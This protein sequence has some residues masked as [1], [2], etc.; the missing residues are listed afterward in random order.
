MDSEKWSAVEELLAASL[1]LPNRERAIFTAR[2]T[3]PTIRNEVIS[4]LK[5][6]TS[7]D[8]RLESVIGGATG[9]PELYGAGP[10]PA[11]FE[12]SREVGQGGMGTVY[13]AID[14][15]RNLRV[16]LKSLS[17]LSPAHL[18]SFK[19][20]F[21]SLRG[22]VHPNL[23]TLY[24]LI[25]EDDAYFL[26]MEFIEGVDFL[27]YVWEASGR[28]YNSERVRA[29]LRQIAAGLAAIHAAGK[30][31]RDIKPSNLMVRHDGRVVILDFGLVADI[32]RS[33]FGVRTEALIG[34]T[35]GYIAPE[36]AAGLLDPASDWYSLGVVLFEALTGRLPPEP[37]FSE[38]GH[39]CPED[40][41][42]LC[43]SLLHLDPAKR[44]SANE[45]LRILGAPSPAAPISAANHRSRPPFVNRLEEMSRLE[46]A[47]S[48][49]CSGRPTVV[50]LSGA[51]GSGKSRL[52][53]RFLERASSATHAI[54]LS[55]KCYEQETVP[56]K[57]VD[58]LIDQLSR[59]LSGSS[60][61][62]RESVIPR[63]MAAL[64]SVFPVLASLP[65]SIP[66]G[67]SPAI[68]DRVELRR[69]AL[70]A[71]REMLDAIG[72]QSR[73][74]LWLDDFQWSDRDT[75]E[76]L[77]EILRPPETPPLLLLCSY[78]S[79]ESPTGHSAVNVLL[80]GLQREPIEKIII[81][82]QPLGTEDAAILAQSILA[83]DSSSNI[84]LREHALAIARDSGGVP[85]FVIEL[86]QA[87]ASHAGENIS[88][89]SMIWER[90]AEQDADARRFMYLTAIAG[91]PVTQ[92]AVFSAAGIVSRSPSIL[93][94]LEN[95]GLLCA[96]GPSPVDT[97]EPFHDRIR[98]AIT[99]RIRLEEKQALHLRLAEALELDQS[100]D[101]ELMAV[102]FEAGGQ[103]TRAGGYYRQAA[104]RAADALAF[105]RAADLYEQTLR[106]VELSPSE[107]SDVELKLA[108]AFA[109]AGRSADASHHYLSAAEHLPPAERLRVEGLASYHLCVAGHLN[110]GRNQIQQ[111]LRRIGRRLVS[112]GFQTMAAL[113]WRDFRCRLRGMQ[114]PPRGAGDVDPVLLAQIDLLWFAAA[115]LGTSDLLGGF[116]LLLWS[117][118][119]AQRAREPAR[120]VRAFSFHAALQF[121]RR[122][123]DSKTDRIFRRCHE[124]SK[125]IGEP[126]ESRAALA[127]TTGIRHYFLGIWPE[128]LS[129]CN[130]AERIM[131]EECHGMNWELAFARVLI[132]TLLMYLGE[133]A[134]LQDLS[135]TM[136]EDAVNRGDLATAATMASLPLPYSQIVSGKPSLARETWRYW[137][138]RWPHRVNSNQESTGVLVE[139][140]SHLYEGEIATAFAV[141]QQAWK[142]SIAGS[143]NLRIPVA[144][145]YFL[146]TRARL[147]LQMAEKSPRDERA[148]LIRKTKGIV[149]KLRRSHCVHAPAHVALIEALTLAM[150]R[151]A[152]R[153]VESM[154]RA[155]SI[156]AQCNMKTHASA[157]RAALGR[158]IGGDRGKQLM[159][160]ADQALR[161]E[162]M[163]DPAAVI[164]MHVGEI[165]PFL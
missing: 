42:R 23:V 125:S 32:E 76:L 136:L 155:S 132:L 135:R 134:R 111:S 49:L 120:M 115:A 8:G 80:E 17:R 13:E 74:I 102:H 29:C 112:P 6:A 70:R 122:L 61:F 56:Y 123:N 20:E 24:E 69:R 44:P 11:R 131:V 160:E 139:A 128:A 10:F 114:Q 33:R 162:R 68:T 28:T 156:F 118:D 66:D 79:D 94:A 40:L 104:G 77:T 31:H 45:V 52:A 96:A 154:T 85:F 108:A 153:A 60:C 101:T 100:A 75:A 59:V 47:F 109:N 150:E 158:W 129:H 16:A 138:E 157:T 50:L 121:A 21:R 19:Q 140:W 110:E 116:Y 148:K 149:G 133:G 163:P 22:V 73:L 165:H 105:N 27:E 12:V 106:L 35:K 127:L 84:G 159:V 124:L 78:R 37:G 81:S 83:R 67:R 161:A 92:A 63:D 142:Q 26:S 25:Q 95:A 5:R 87:A 88:V 86:T 143:G 51:A 54:V 97:V 2:I 103:L 46:S 89:Q 71:L 57:G 9:L 152:S 151:R 41:V 164:R 65:F 126:P 48:V 1:A 141:L 38:I 14:T 64:S 98:E 30:L 34:G 91:R 15:E 107:R 113:L 137:R 3:D 147:F 119:L 36:Q 4:L 18:Y 53:E 90:L 7:A 43:K 62:R 117:L 145:V 39:E 82:L 130:E 93:N 146:E 72:S 144:A 58:S 99:A 55:G